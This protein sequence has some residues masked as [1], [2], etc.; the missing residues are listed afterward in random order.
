M[1][2]RNNPIYFLF[3]LYFFR[4]RAAERL[5]GFLRES[6]GPRSL[7]PPQFR[8]RYLIGLVISHVLL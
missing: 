4:R 5:R 8:N 7:F 6:I 3:V 1:E 2:E